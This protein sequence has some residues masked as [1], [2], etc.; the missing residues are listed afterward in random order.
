MKKG[1]PDETFVSVF[2]VQKRDE[3][4]N[5]NKTKQIQLARVKHD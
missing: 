5:Q 2:M 4:Q 1:K 3:N